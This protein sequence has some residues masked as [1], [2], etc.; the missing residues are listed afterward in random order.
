MRGMERR[1]F[2]LL[3]TL[4]ALAILGVAIFSMVGWLA[5]SVSFEE[6]LELHRLAIR[7]LEAQHESMRAGLPL[8]GLDGSYLVSPLTDLSGLDS[9]VIRLTVA[10]RLPAGLY[11][12]HFEARYRIGGQRF[13]RHVDSLT[14]RP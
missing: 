10:P 8:P 9:P 5:R 3:E 7:E 12:V 4:I 1:G 6:R 2:S 14:W 13:E 11:A